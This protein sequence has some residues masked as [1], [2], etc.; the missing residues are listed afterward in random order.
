MSADA[1]CYASASLKH[2]Q[3]ALQL[4]HSCNK[5]VFGKYNLI[6]LNINSVLICQSKRVD[7]SQSNT[8]DKKEIIIIIKLKGKIQS[9]T[10]ETRKLYI[11]C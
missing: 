9:K 4:Q 10:T 3:K 7:V 5:L 2:A 11:L 1:V 6:Y 8:E